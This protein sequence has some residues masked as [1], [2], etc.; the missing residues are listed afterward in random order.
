MK[1]SLT[2]RKIPQCSRLPSSGYGMWLLFSAVGRPCWSSEPVPGRKSEFP[3]F[4]LGYWGDPSI[5]PSA[6]LQNSLSFQIL[7]LWNPY[8]ERSSYWAK[9][10]GGSSETLVRTGL[11]HHSTVS[12]S[13]SHSAVVTGDCMSGQLET[14]KLTRRSMENSELQKGT[15]WGPFQHR[16]KAGGGD[17]SLSE[18]MCPP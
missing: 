11:S 8:R 17:P 14:L 9:G 12:L 2:G 16:E 7:W 4:L 1:S 6:N 15:K 10:M 18:S 3:R 13:A 5:E